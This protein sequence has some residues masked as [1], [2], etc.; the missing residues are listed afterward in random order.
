MANILAFLDD[1]ARKAT[2]VHIMYDMNG[3]PR[4]EAIVQMDSGQ[5]ACACHGAGEAVGVSVQIRQRAMSTLHTHTGICLAVKMAE[6]ISVQTR[7]HAK[8]F[9]NIFSRT[10]LLAG[11]AAKMAEVATCGKQIIFHGKNY[12]LEATQISKEEMFSKAVQ[13]QTLPT[14]GSAGTSVYS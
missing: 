6:G 14:G 12:V 7:S 4:G 3:M 11:D 10:F 1:L 8:Q 13:P 2:S 9:S 5:C